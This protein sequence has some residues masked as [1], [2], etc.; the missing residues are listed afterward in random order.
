MSGTRTVQKRQKA[1]SK[2]TDQLR[3]TKH[4]RQGDRVWHEGVVRQVKTLVR[5]PGSGLMA[6]EFTDGTQFA[7]I[8][9]DKS[10]RLATS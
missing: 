5:T 2:R 1:P 7:S 8:P 4:E 3:Q 6:V 10:W 9:C